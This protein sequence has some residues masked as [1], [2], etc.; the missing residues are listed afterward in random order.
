M[1]N[2]GSRI[3]QIGSGLIISKPKFSGDQI[4]K[5]IAIELIV[6]YMKLIKPPQ[7]LPSI[8]TYSTRTHLP[9]PVLPQYIPTQE[10]RRALFPQHIPTQGFRRTLFSQ[11]TSL[12]KKAC[13]SKSQV[14]GLVQIV[15]RSA[16]KN[17]A[18]MRRLSSALFRRV[19]TLL[20]PGSRS[21]RLEQNQESKRRRYCNPTLWLIK[22]IRRLG[23]NLVVG[24]GGRNRS[25]E[26]RVAWICNR[27]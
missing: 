23:K 25:R 9:K 24:F 10:S 18:P 1:H 19:L 8:R 17:M 16:E 7:S 11:A 27:R 6:G 2:P 15:I 3:N 22:L 26:G 5:S 14:D 12:R 13:P 21:A 4:Q 20:E